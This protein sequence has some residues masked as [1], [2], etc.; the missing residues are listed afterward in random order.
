MLEF[1]VK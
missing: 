1:N